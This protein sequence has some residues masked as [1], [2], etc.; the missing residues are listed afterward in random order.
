MRLLK[1]ERSLR[2]VLMAHAW[3]T[4]A[5]VGPTNPTDDDESCTLGH[6]RGSGAG[7]IV[8]LQFV[9][10]VYHQIVPAMDFF[11]HSSFVN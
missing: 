11:S 1:K 9:I 2:A 6:E 10:G 5:S 4:R 7:G 8:S 3:A